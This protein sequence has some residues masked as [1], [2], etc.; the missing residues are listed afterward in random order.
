[1]TVKLDTSDLKEIQKYIWQKNIDRGFAE[2]GAEKK[3]LMLTEEVGELAKAIREHIGMG[4]SSTT[5]KSEAAE[6]IADVLI[7][8]LGLASKLGIDIHQALLDK[9]SKNEKRAW[10]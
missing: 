3:M 6:E 8:T 5:S 1:M 2:E 10:K 9:E 4:F 7:I